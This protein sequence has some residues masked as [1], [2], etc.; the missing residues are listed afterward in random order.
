MVHVPLPTTELNCTFP[1]PTVTV[2][3]NPNVDELRSGVEVSVHAAP[4]SSHVV[5]TVPNL[6][7]PPDSVIQ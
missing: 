5:I 3:P 2:N 6:L 7:A 1:P 4:L